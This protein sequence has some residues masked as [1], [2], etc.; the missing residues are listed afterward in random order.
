MNEAD[1]GILPSDKSGSAVV[2]VLW[3]ALLMA[4]LLATA[5]AVARQ[6]AQIAAADAERLKARA[7][8]LSALDVAAWQIATGGVA[9]FRRNKGIEFLRLNDYDVSV[10]LTPENFKTNLNRADET[11]LAAVLQNAGTDYERANNLAAEIAD[12]RDAD[13]LTRVNG[14]EK[15]DYINRNGKEIH[16]RPF[17]S[18]SELTLVLS[19]TQA[20]ISCLYRLLTVHGGAL[21][22]LSGG[23]V[24]VPE[25][26]LHSGQLGTQTRLS[27]LGEQ[28]VLRA[29]ARH[30]R[31][32][33]LFALTAAI[34]VTGAEEKPFKYI[35][36]VQPP[37]LQIQSG[38]RCGD[39]NQ[40]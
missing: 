23:E 26:A 8:M 9:R 2:F 30:Q 6:E 37:K 16:N 33:R 34:R 18:L 29:Q 19:V 20:D 36:F 28:F 5:L 14:A 27:E 40:I 10:S 25:G 39:S 24:L 3:M 38:N 15:Q 7:A 22:T 11:R 35:G 32:A 21:S 31:S 17:A 4:S 12:W 13:D 1:A